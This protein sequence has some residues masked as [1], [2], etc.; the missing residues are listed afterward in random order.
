MAECTR[1]ES[2]RTGKKRSEGSNPSVP[3]SV[4]CPYPLMVRRPGSQLVNLGS[5]PNRG[6][7]VSVC[8]RGLMVGQQ[9]PKLL[10]VGSSPAEGAIF[11]V[12]VRP[13]PLATGGS[14]TWSS[15]QHVARLEAW[16]DSSASVR[17]VEVSS[18]FLLGI[19]RPVRHKSV[20]LAQVTL[21]HN[22][23]CSFGP[24]H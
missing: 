23:P 18:V 8:L 10:G 14:D 4:H 16:A 9:P 24:G 6:T 5:N 1:L 20:K 12:G 17:K 21:L 22:S 3:A 15:C 2:E 7:S 13:T 19:S 11:I